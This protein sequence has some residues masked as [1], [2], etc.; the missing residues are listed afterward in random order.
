MMVEFHTSNEFFHSMNTIITLY[1]VRGF[2][3]V[4]GRGN[5]EKIFPEWGRWKWLGCNS[6]L[7]K[8]NS[9]NQSKRFHRTSSEIQL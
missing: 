7:I 8:E 6:I 9:E 5:F 1:G 4:S 2:R 3:I